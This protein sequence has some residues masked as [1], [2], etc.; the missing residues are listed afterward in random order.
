MIQM[1]RKI[2]KSWRM[3]FVLFCLLFLNACIVQRSV[4]RQ[5]ELTLHVTGGTAPLANVSIYL[6]W[7]SNPYSRLEETQ[8][9]TTDEEGNVRLEQLLQSDSAY[10][11]ALHGVSY[12][13]HKLCIE[14]EGYLTLLVTLTALPGEEIRLD[15]PLT[16]GS[17]LPICSDYKMLNHHPGTSRPDVTTQHPSLQGAYEIRGE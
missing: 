4:V 16:E 9:F 17:S 8:T 1:K 5:P 11:L 13:E 15:V 3:R 14:A 12:F 10:P 6:Y 7:L 2:A